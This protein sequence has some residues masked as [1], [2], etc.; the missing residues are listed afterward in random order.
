MNNKNS[1]RYAPASIHCPQC[2]KNNRM[3]PVRM[4]L[5]P[6]KNVA[7]CPRCDSIYDLAE[8]ATAPDS[9]PAS[10]T[11]IDAL[12]RMFAAQKSAKNSHK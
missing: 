2:R 4:L 10:E 8:P 9:E 6:V 1:V 7:I 11:V 3:M 5:D 12:Q